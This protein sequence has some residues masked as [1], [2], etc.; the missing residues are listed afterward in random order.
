MSVTANLTTN[1]ETITAT[2]VVEDE[3][4]IAQVS[5]AARGPAGP[6]GSAVINAATQSDGTADLDLLNVTTATATVTGTLTADHIHGNLAGSVYSHIRAGENLAKGDPVYVSGSHG[7]GSTLIPIVSKAD[8]SNAAKMPAIGIMDAD[9]ANNANGHMVITGTITELDTAGLTVNAELYVAAGGGMTATPPTARAQPVA[10]VERANLNNGAVIVKVNGLSASDATGNTLVRRTSTG[11]ASFGPLTTGPLSATAISSDTNSITSSAGTT[12]TGPLT[13]SGTGSNT[14]SATYS[15]TISLTG[16]TGVTIAG[17][18]L[19]LNSSGFAYGAGAAAAH[20]TALG[21]GTT[22]SPTFAGASLGTFTG[23]FQINP[24]GPT[25]F[26]GAAGIWYYTYFGTRRMQVDAARGFVCSPGLGFVWTGTSN[27]STSVT[28]LALLRDAAGTLAQRNGLNAQES[29]IYGTYTDTSNYRRLAL[30]MSSAGV[31]QIVAEGAGSG[32]AGNVLQIEGLTIGKGGGAVSTNTALGTSAL[33][34]NT[35][36]TDNAAIG[37]Q[38]LIANTTGSRNSASGSASMFA[39][40][41]GSD[42]T[43][44]GTFALFTNVSSSENTALGSRALQLN[45]GGSNTAVGVSSLF[46]NTTGSNNS[47]FGQRAG[48][49]I[50]DGTTSNAITNNSVYLGAETKALA[51]GQTNQIVIGHNATGIGSNT[52]VLGNDSIATTA[53]KGNVGIGT[54][55]PGSKLAVNGG[56]ISVSNTAGS[57]LSFARPGFLTTSFAINSSNA[58]TVGGS[59]VEF[60]QGVSIGYGTGGFLPATGSLYVSGNVGIGTTSPASKLDVVGAIKASA[61]VQTGGYTFATLPTP[62]QGMRTFITDG[63]AIPIF[64]ANAA[65]GGST[66]TPVFYNGTNWINC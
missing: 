57:M 2:I 48:R 44:L 14:L 11:G 38:S 63:T 65:G 25:L 52:A 18:T 9:V 56:S 58:M 12:I 29:R 20:R 32:L 10:R 40:T 17:G 30:K 37:Y 19:T 64:M 24:T 55:S 26:S 8:A 6:A 4:I 13:L 35:T 59:S 22:D 16:T 51:S 21:L 23:T 50:A 45:T 31:A 61:T 62:A 7:S 28:E 54:T 34:A 43:A 47:S 39:N 42:N 33:N 5:A 36:G 66:V 27:D 53:L 1:V 49:F 60:Q 46:A 41:T 15:N 3:T